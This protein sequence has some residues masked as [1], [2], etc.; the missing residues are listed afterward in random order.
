MVCLLIFHRFPLATHHHRLIFS[1]SLIHFSVRPNRSLRIYL[2]LRDLHCRI[3][4]NTSMACAL[5]KFASYFIHQH[6]KSQF[7]FYSFRIHVIVWYCVRSRKQWCSLAGL[8]VVKVSRAS[9]N[10][11]YQLDICGF[12][13]WRLSLRLWIEVGTCELWLKWVCMCARSRLCVCVSSSEY[14]LFI[15]FDLIRSVARRS[16][17]EK[18]KTI[19]EITNVRQHAAKHVSTGKRPG[20]RF[21]CEVVLLCNSK[22][23][24]RRKMKREGGGGEREK[25]K[26]MEISSGYLAFP[27][28]SV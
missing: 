28:H 2:L 15:W 8:D 14:E 12:V 18:T 13:N 7:Q 3:V 1:L 19:N 24:T 23:R 20:F 27:C 11:Q 21:E 6:H 25:K 10:K 17:N 22:S 9:H 16:D 5:C 4:V 26:M